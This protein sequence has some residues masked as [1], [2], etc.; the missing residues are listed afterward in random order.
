MMEVA[1]LTVALGLGT[2]A[3]IRAIGAGTARVTSSGA[4][5]LDGD[6][7]GD[8]QRKAELPRPGARDR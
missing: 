7:Q 5:A 2:A 6:G 1:L 3:G 4:T 8:D